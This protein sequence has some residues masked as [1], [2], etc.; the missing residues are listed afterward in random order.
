MAKTPKLKR[1]RNQVLGSVVSRR[2]ADIVF[3]FTQFP[4]CKVKLRG[5][6]REGGRAGLT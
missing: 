6:G 1:N 5:T 4:S 3:S 2:L